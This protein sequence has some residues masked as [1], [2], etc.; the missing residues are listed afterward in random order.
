LHNTGSAKDKHWSSL[1]IR[2][3]W[4]FPD[5]QILIN[6]HVYIALQSE[7]FFADFAGSGKMFALLQIAIP[8]AP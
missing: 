6:N 1:F 7:I 2:K 3:E 5:K 4:P 8:F